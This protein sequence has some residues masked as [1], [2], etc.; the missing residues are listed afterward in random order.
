MASSCSS[1]TIR[2]CNTCAAT[3]DATGVQDLW[4]AL[5]LV[6]VLE[7]LMLFVAPG[8]WKRAAEQMTGLSDGQL[9]R[10]GGVILALGLASLYVV[11]G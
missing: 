7:G 8:G 5:C 10:L 3:A 11:R 2:S 4:A 9:R 1:A 6:V